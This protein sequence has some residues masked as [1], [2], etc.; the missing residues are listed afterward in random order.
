MSDVKDK[1]IKLNK[2]QEFINAYKVLRELPEHKWVLVKDLEN[3][4]VSHGVS[5]YFSYP[6]INYC[7]DKGYV[8]STSKETYDDM[9]EN[10]VR[11]KVK[12]T[13]QGKKLLKEMEEVIGRMVKISHFLGPTWG[14]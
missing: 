10:K 4:T 1:G 12:L 13:E 6:F 2:I 9:K 11:G 7:V 14:E 5:Y 8:S 3:T